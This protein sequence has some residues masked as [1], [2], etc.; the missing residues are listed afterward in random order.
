MTITMTQISGEKS[1]RAP[2]LRKEEIKAGISDF[3]SASKVPL[4][5]LSRYM[6]VDDPWLSSSLGE[7]VKLDEDGMLI[8]QVDEPEEITE[9][10]FELPDQPLRP[11]K[12]WRVGSG[13]RTG[14]GGQSKTLDAT[15]TLP[16]KVSDPLP[17][18]E[19]LHPTE[20]LIEAIFNPYPSTSKTASPFTYYVPPGSTPKPEVQK[21]GSGISAASV[22]TGTDGTSRG[23]FDSS[24][25]ASGSASDQGHESSNASG[26][27][28]GHK[29]WK[30][31]TGSRPI[32][33][34]H[35]DSARR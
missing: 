15:V 32:T 8:P 23:S 1:Y 24:Q 27:V 4:P 25:R 6:P 30:R 19:Q 35:M 34:S 29:W 9:S 14:S 26:S 16:P 11:R 20:V 2:L 10:S 28:S 12:R 33:P 7:F 22:R 18:K 3:L 5:S 17:Q 13:K 31:K 21:Q